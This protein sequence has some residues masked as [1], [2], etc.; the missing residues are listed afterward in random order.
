MEGYSEGEGHMVFFNKDDEEEVHE[1]EDMS[2]GVRVQPGG[3]NASIMGG[4]R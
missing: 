2:V 3:D 1:E 4:S